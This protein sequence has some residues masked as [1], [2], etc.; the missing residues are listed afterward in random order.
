MNPAAYCVKCKEYT[1]TSSSKTVLLKN[2]SRALTGVCPKCQS[3]VFKIIPKKT[4]A[5]TVSS[6]ASS[7]ANARYQDKRSVYQLDTVFSHTAY[8]VR[9]KKKTQVDYAHGIIFK[10]GRKA[11]RGQCDNC[12][13][14]AYKILKEKI[15]IRD[16]SASRK[17]T[18]TATRRIEPLQLGR[19]WRVYAAWLL[20]SA[21]VG[22]GLA[23]A[24]KYFQYF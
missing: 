16:V 19:S 18:A 10:N 7:V 8:C 5:S 1:D 9:C 22:A 4:V 23:Y 21:V 17:L 14:D 13:C 3:Q 12:G 24:A 2:N 15:V 20:G 6:T 11:L